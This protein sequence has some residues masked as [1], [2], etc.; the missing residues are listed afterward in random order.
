[1]S[2]PTPP[3][4]VSAPPPSTSS[5]EEAADSALPRAAQQAHLQ[6]SL[7]HAQV[8]S[9]SLSPSTTPL[10]GTMTIPSTPP[11]SPSPLLHAPVTQSAG[12]QGVEE[13]LS[14]SLAAQ[15][16]ANSSKSFSSPSPLPAQGSAQ[17]QPSAAGSRDNTNKHPNF[18]NP[19]PIAKGATA[20]LTDTPSPILSSNSPSPQA[21]SSSSLV[22]PSGVGQHL[23]NSGAPAAGSPPS[24]VVAPALD[25]HS[26]SLHSQQNLSS[27]IS[28]SNSH[29]LPPAHAQASS[30]AGGA[31]HKNS[32]VSSKA[33]DPAAESQL[34]QLFAEAKAAAAPA[35]LSYSLWKS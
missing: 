2:V 26:F 34:Q 9:V 31:K 25:A 23:A 16:E 19:A 6:P 21:T 1:M 29:A 8:E 20:M 32:G 11:F 30:A 35:S 7:P 33:I 15:P 27:G 18:S 13:P 3:H 12:V 14:L 28:L 4:A 5:G 17:N 24:A 10:D 22:H